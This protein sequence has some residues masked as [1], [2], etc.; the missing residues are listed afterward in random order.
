MENIKILVVDDDQDIRDSLRALLESQQYSVITAADFEEAREK[1]K[2]EKPD[3]FILDVMLNTHKDGF[4]ISRALKN[5]PR[6]KDTPI[7]MLTGVKQQ[8]GID[9]KTMAGD[10]TWCPVDGFLDKPVKPDILLA[11][12]EKLLIRRV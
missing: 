4:D 6:F 2:T 10:P 3:L 1:M 5:D 8:T 12:L 11:E 9:F 7:L